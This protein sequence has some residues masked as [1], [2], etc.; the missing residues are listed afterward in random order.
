[1]FQY[2]RWHYEKG[3]RDVL[4]FSKNILWFIWNFFSVTLLFKTLF[5][6][7]QRLE[8]H[9]KRGDLAGL[10]EALII[11]TLMRL[12]GAFIRIVFI[13]VGLVAM[14]LGFFLAIALEVLWFLL[15]FV[16]VG[17]FIFGLILVF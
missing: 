17:S 13:V 6:P 3:P 2:L 5:Y 9:H 1:M 11:N 12:I 8:E 15:P 14:V 16:V 7:W 10:T 4:E